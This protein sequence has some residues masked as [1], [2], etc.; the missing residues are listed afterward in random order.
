MNHS[1]FEKM[2]AAAVLPGIVEHTVLTLL[3]LVRK[4]FHYDSWRE[5]K[6]F[7]CGF[8]AF[9]FLGLSRLSYHVGVPHLPRIGVT[10]M[11]L[12]QFIRDTLQ[13]LTFLKIFVGPFI[14][15]VIF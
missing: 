3:F 11:F 1:V 8:W 2:T 14:F 12:L 7:L 9:F 6:N 4:N 15:F 5:E 10:D 13:I